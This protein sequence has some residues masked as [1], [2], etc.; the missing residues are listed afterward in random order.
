M[1]SVQAVRQYRFGGP[2]VLAVEEVADLEP[3]VGQVR[4]AVSA[5]GVHL[6]DLWI[7]APARRAARFPCPTCR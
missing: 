4:I 1:A 6:L 7:C 3:P 5:T 2:A